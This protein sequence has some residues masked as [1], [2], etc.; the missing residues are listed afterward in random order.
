MVSGP[1][2]DEVVFQS[3]DFARSCT[4][5]TQTDFSESGWSRL[6]TEDVCPCMP[7][8]RS[9]V[10]SQPLQ[11][12]WVELLLES[13]PSVTRTVLTELTETIGDLRTVIGEATGVSRSN[14]ELV[15]S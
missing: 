10:F 4:Q 7:E 15:I 8:K 3:G 11:P 12:R 6:C 13:S 2:P 1:N 5:D 9:C 14:V